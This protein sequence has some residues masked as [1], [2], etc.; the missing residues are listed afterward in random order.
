MTFDVG[1]SLYMYNGNR[2]SLAIG[3]RNFLTIN[4]NTAGLSR[5]N[6]IV[7]ILASHVLAII[8]CWLTLQKQTIVNNEKLFIMQP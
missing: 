6:I 7:Y 8:L 5:K 1:R 3:T 2:V 4:F